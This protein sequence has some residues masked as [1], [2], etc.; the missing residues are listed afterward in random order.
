MNKPSIP[1]YRTLD[2]LKYINTG[3]VRRR[4]LTR[5]GYTP[6]FPFRAPKNFITPKQ[7]WPNTIYPI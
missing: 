5:R 2:F 3:F 6:H 4:R 7:M 1:R